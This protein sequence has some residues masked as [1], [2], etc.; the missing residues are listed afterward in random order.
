MR[1]ADFQPSGKE[2]MWHAQRTLRRRLRGCQPAEQSFQ[3]GAW[4]RN[5]KAKVVSGRIRD[6][7]PMIGIGELCTSSTTER[8]LCS[9]S[10]FIDAACIRPM[11][12]TQS[13]TFFTA[14]GDYRFTTPPPPEAWSKRSL[15]RLRRCIASG[16]PSVCNRTASRLSSSPPIRCSSRK[17]AISS[18]STCHRP[19][20][21]SCCVSMRKTGFRRSTARSPV[22]DVALRGGAAH[23]RL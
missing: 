12:S 21:R 18:G 16:V 22:A 19:N 6:Y 8:S 10:P 20:A 15:M 2:S 7:P 1:S 23:A 4:C 17:C 9:N 13:R 3:I 14:D 11:S 5:S